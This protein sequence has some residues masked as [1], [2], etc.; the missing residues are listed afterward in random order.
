MIGFSQ[1]DTLTSQPIH[2]Q[3]LVLYCPIDKLLK[4]NSHKLGFES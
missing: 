1:N 2:R 4:V 3:I